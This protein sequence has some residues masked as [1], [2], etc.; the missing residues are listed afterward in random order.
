MKTGEILGTEVAGVNQI[1]PHKNKWAWDIFLKGIA[2]NWSPMEISMSKDIE[3]WRSKSAFTD[4]ERLL[5]KR[6]LG[7][8]A[9]SESLVSNNLLLTVFRYCVDPEVRQQILRQSFEECGRAGT[10]WL[11][12]RG[13]VEFTQLKPNDLVAQY[14]T[15]GSIEFVP[16]TNPVTYDFDGE[17]IRISNKNNLTE[18]EVTPNHRMVYRSENNDGVIGVETASKISYFHKQH[19]VAGKK[20]GGRDYLTMKERFLIAL[21][22]DG[23]IP[24]N[25]NRFGVTTVTFHF[26]KTRKIERLQ[27]I[28]NELGW[29]YT[30]VD[31]KDGL[32][33]KFLVRI[34]EEELIPTKELSEWVRLDDISS[35]WCREFVDELKRWDG[36]E[37][38]RY[39]CVGYDS[40]NKS[41][42][43]IAQAIGILAGYRTNYRFDPDDR[44]ETFSDLHRLTFTDKD[45]V[46]RGT[47]KKSKVP[48]KGKV[49]CLSVPSGMM[50]VRYN[51][52]VSITGN[53]LHNLTI[54]YVCDSLGLDINEVY[55]AYNNIPSIKAKDDFLMSATTD[56]NRRDFDPSTFEA[57][58]E[59]LRSLITFFLVCEGIMFYSGFAML[60]SFG[61]QG[62]LPGI[63]E[64]IS[65][66]LRDESLHI[67][68]GTQL[69]NT[70]KEQNP[71]LWTPEFQQETIEH[72]K[73][74]TELEIAYVHNVLP[75]GILGL[76]AEMFI[77]YMQYIS[78]RRLEG[79]GLPK[80]Y[81]NPRNPFSWMSEVIDLGKQKNFFETRVT[82]Y[83][84]AGSLKDDF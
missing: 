80:L 25:K 30:L 28:I 23:S 81:E 33:K 35:E 72:I 69:I 45:F 34:P 6:C 62:K 46:C 43:D 73:K 37:Y 29:E 77:D 19:L 32:R 76:N 71:E 44:K 14:N 74:A 13:W 56:I 66:T 10:E 42:I 57:K 78:N 55:E 26:A 4:D 18:L 16:Y 21:Q 67:A 48:Y 7:F 3:Q 47:I 54:V 24:C 79:I 51:N 11:T 84:T 2:N 60:L 70:I 5:V 63:C 41:A 22:A 40:T 82:D 39:D 68:F 58:Q 49:H 53:S 75:R 9:G 65:Y 15:D 20:T 27:W 36:W 61:R 38:E 12:P 50:V 17:L 59:I 52:S 1:L 83:K 8:F 31:T 64:N